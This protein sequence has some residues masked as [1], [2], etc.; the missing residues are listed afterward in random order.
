MNI[1]SLVIVGGGLA[2]WTAAAGFASAFKNM[3]IRISVVEHPV[4]DSVADASLPSVRAFHSFLK[5]SEPDLMRNTKATFNLATEYVGWVAPHHR[6]MHAFSAHGFMIDSVQFHHYAALLKQCG[7][8]TPFDTYSLA[9]Q[10]ANLGKF[11]FLNEKQRNE[12][13][14][15]DFG[16]SVE[17]A[18][19]TQYMKNIA[20]KLGVKSIEGR[21]ATSTFNASTGGIGYVVLQDDQQVDGDFFIDATGDQALLIDKLDK[22]GE[23]SWEEKIPVTHSVTVTVPCSEEG[24]PV[25]TLKALS[26]GILKTLR[27]KEVQVH[28]FYY[29]T[30][31]VSHDQ[32][33]QILKQASHPM[34]DLQPV[35]NSLHPKKRKQFWIKNCL[36]LGASAVEM[37]GVGVS[38]LHLIQSGILRFA[39][40]FPHQSD[41][42]LFA[43]EYNRLTH[44]EYDRMM[45]FIQVPFTLNKVMRSPYWA[46][47]REVVLSS[48]LEHKLALFETRGI[49]AFYE[50]ETW[51]PNVWA[52]LLLG[53]DLWPKKTDPLIESFDIAKISQVLNQ[54]K[55]TYKQYAEDMPSH[56]EFLEHFYRFK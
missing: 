54:I 44:I 17:S 12:G 56:K 31:V 21:V 43:E 35:V 3:N 9:A 29:S 48:E 50:Q 33:A 6:Y 5:V 42:T 14:Q 32:A 24:A 49:V 22:G 19:Y 36:A 25:S 23:I 27:L 13:L 45:D 18:T 40:L 16:I 28:S 7:D 11:N 34:M 39:D 38:S 47:A 53:F 8:T 2:G 37:G 55:G 15:L 4:E 46:Y 1:Q 20:I 30:L 10:M 51:M 52:S 41:I 26:N